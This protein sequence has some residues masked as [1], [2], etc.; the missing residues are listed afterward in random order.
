MSQQE[1]ISVIIPAYNCGGTICAAIDSVLQ[2]TYHNIE[3]IVVDDNSTDNT[4]AEVERAM[5]KD[6][7]VRLVE[8]PDDPNRFDKRTGR[9]INAGWSAR[10]AAIAHARGAVITFQDADD[11]SLLNRIEVQYE[12]LKKYSAVH[13]TTDWI[14]F[15]PAYVGKRLDV[16]KYLQE[17]SDVIIGPEQLYR[18]SQ[19]VKGLIPKFSP[20]LNKKIPFH[21]KR[22]RVINKLFWGSLESYP[23]IPGIIMVRREV[24]DTVRFRPLPERL[25]PS[26]MG[27]GVDR[28][29]DF[30]VA[31]TFK[32]SYVIKL[33][34]YMWRVSSENPE[35]TNRIQSYLTKE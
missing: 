8:A 19:R 18:M 10:N 14:Q 28:D 17:H 35:Y 25:W 12:L 1:L 31:E 34:L 2:Q 22:M 7:R 13:I 9:N 33:P 3:V 16:E 30:Q 26:F 20:A 23:G 21:I 5:Q 29:F 32:N 24:F 27:R 15:N 4:K 11:V 6:P